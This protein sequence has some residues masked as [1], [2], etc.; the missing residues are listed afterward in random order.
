MSIGFKPLRGLAL[1]TSLAALGCHAQKPI[2]APAQS[3]IQ[4]A[5]S[6]AI[7]PAVQVGVKL[8]ADLARRIEVMIRS[9]SDI[10]IDYTVTV[11]E[12]AKSDISGF[13]L[14]TVSF[15]PDGKPAKSAPFLLSVDGKTLA[16][17]N[18]FDISQDPAAK[19]SAEGRP[20][21]G[22]PATAPVTIVGYDDLECPFCAIMNAT[23]FPAVVNRYKD[24]V[25]IVYRDFPL[26]ELHPWAKHAAIDANCLA[27]G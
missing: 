23:L 10:P 5:Q 11:G 7:T 8:P 6:A 17:L 26:E 1:S 18:R 3:S 27:A 25:R 19:V 9:K 16:Q 2:Q 15:A 22:G 12:P 21:R 24:Q 13:D 4:A 14:I 20:S